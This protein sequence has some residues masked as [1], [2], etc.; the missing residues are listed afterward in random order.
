MTS[1]ATPKDPPR[2][3]AC[4]RCHGSLLREGDVV[5]CTSC[6]A[7][8]PVVTPEGAPRGSEVIDFLSQREQN[9]K[10]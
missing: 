1:P 10:P 3:I 5:A 2:E 7:R 8:H 6:H 9:A 4:P